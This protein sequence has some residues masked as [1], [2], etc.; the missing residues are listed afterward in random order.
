[1]KS[2][3][4]RQGDVSLIPTEKVKGEKVKHEGSFV[5]AEGEATGHAHIITVPSVDNMAIYKITPH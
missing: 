5:L 2:K 4:Y 3:V 1:M